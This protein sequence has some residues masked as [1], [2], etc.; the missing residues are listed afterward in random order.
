MNQRSAQL[1]ALLESLIDLPVDE[2][3]ARLDADC[4][5]PDLRAEVEELLRHHDAEQQ[6]PDFLQAVTDIIESPSPKAASVSTTK[7]P[8]ASIGPYRIISRLG[9]GGMGTVYLAEHQHLRKQ[10]ALKLLPQDA[11]ASAEL[12]SRFRREMQSAGK[13][14]HDNVVRASDAGESENGFFLAMERVDGPNLEELVAQHGPLSIADACE[15]ARQAADGIAHAHDHGIIHRDIKPSNLMITADGRVKVVDFGLALLR[16]ATTTALTGSQHVMGTID[17]M[18][19]EQATHN[20]SIDRRTDIYSLGATLYKLLTGSAPFEEDHPVNATQTLVSL[21]T[22]QPLPIGE[23]RTDLPAALATYI[24]RMLDPVPDNRPDSAAEISATLAPLAADHQLPSL[25]AGDGSHQSSAPVITPA[26][27]V[28]RARSRREAVWTGLI[29]LIIVG[30]A[31]W[32]FLAPD[33]SGEEWRTTSNQRSSVISAG[34]IRP[35]TRTV[36]AWPTL[37][38]WTTEPI[39]QLGPVIDRMYQLCE[40]LE[41]VPADEFVTLA[42]L[43]GDLNAETWQAAVTTVQILIRLNNEPTVSAAELRAAA[44]EL[45]LQRARVDAQASEEVWITKPKGLSYEDSTEL[46]TA[47]EQDFADKFPSTSYTAVRERFS[48]TDWESEIDYSA[49]QTELI[50]PLD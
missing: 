28:R 25:V 36:A 16:D 2:R 7:S 6:S 5:D 12:V 40:Q 37:Q 23:R 14:D 18:S 22:S 24:D 31:G 21:A 32:W 9:R 11:M 27:S 29:A 17:Y 15:I 8:P 10:V 39:D 33:D 13:L 30:I 45:D 41:L 42:Y 34:R 48:A 3:R 20:H 19:P 44:E 47:L 1:E 26:Q 49:L 43:D 38:C 35:Q 50:I 4:A 46:W